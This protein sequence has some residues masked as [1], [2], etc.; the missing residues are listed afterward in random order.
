MLNPLKRITL[1]D[2]VLEALRRYIVAQSLAP[3]AKLPTERELSQGLAVSRTV[4]REALS[5]LEAQGLI[6]RRTSLGYYVTERGAALAAS[7]PNGEE[8]AWDDLVRAWEVRV[9][10]EVG[11]VLVLLPHLTDK[12]LSHLERAALKLDTMMDHQEAHAEAEVDFHLEVFKVT[13]NKALFS[14]AHTVLGE[15]FRAL[16]IARPDSFFI[17]PNEASARR[18]LPLIQAFRQRD[19]QTMQQAV[20]LH[21]APPPPPERRAEQSA[22]P[23]SAVQNSTKLVHG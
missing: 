15:Y 1:R 12:A 5:V 19:L 14:L 8:A 17:R 4:V 13:G 9:T 16:A 2:Q 23:I 11:V 20:W 10:L 21:C 7:T 18:H 3:G 6:D 22:L